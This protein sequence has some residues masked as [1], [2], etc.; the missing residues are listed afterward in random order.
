MKFTKEE[1]YK[2]LVAKLTANGEKLSLSE[3][4]INEQLE[5]LM[6]LV[7]NEETELSDFVSK[8]L[9][10]FKTANSNIRN[11]VSTG[12]K[13]YEEKNPYKNKV[14]KTEKE[15]GEKSDLEKRMEA[16]EVELSEAKRKEQIN[17][18]KTQLRQALKE[19]GVNDEE[20]INALIPEV[21]IDAEFKVED[22]VEKY[23]TLFNKSKAKIVKD[24]TPDGA[25][26]GT[27]DEKY[28]SDTIN[29]AADFA[30]AQRL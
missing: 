22:K 7:A 23:V 1:A 14:K 16:L 18:I 2:D 20:W 5:T 15:E 3:R 27:D 8:T 29:A 21:A 26:G 28:L 6:P 19:K 17:S 11:D 24:R 13:D 25:G 12:I 10:L 30:K 9:A 4:S